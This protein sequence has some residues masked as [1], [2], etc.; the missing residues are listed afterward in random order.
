MWIL[1]VKSTSAFA[2][3]LMSMLFAAIIVSA[4]PASAASWNFV[5]SSSTAGETYNV[6][7]GSSY[8]A[9][10]SAVRDHDT[11]DEVIFLR[12]K[13]AD[14]KGQRVTWSSSSGSGACENNAGAGTSKAC[15]VSAP[16]GGRLYY[17]WCIKE[18]STMVYCKS[19]SI[20][21]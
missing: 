12:D 9:S 7:Y 18:G 6:Y 4:A 8:R 17:K 19:D 3:A 10:I 16:E 2:A 11:Y 13:K 15:N 1:V 14:G 5:Y 21:G 20:L